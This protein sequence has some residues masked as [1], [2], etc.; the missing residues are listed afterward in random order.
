MSK[1]ARLAAFTLNTPNLSNQ[2]QFYTDRWGLEAVEEHAGSVYLRAEGPRHHV[3]SLHESQEKGLRSIVFEATPG[4]GLN[5]I[6]E[7]LLEAGVEVVS[8]PVGNPHAGIAKG[9]TFKDPD[10]NLIEI[11]EGID[12]NHE[13]YGNRDV[14]PQDVNH[15]VVES[16]D[17]TDCTSSTQRPWALG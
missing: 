16:P 13:K 1:V 4:Y 10:G 11:V 12:V 17:A 2:A 5:R 7:E 9:L 3:L 14:K 6:H 15:A 8:G